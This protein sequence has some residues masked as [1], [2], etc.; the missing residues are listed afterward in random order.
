MQILNYSSLS[1][2][3]IKNLLPLINYAI[4]KEKMLPNLLLY[5][6]NKSYKHIKTRHK[7]KIQ[8][9]SAE[10]IHNNKKYLSISIFI[11]NLYGSYPYVSMYR[12]KAGEATI[13]NIAEQIVII[14]AHE[15]RH[16]YQYY[17]KLKLSKNW[18]KSEDDA[19]IYAIKVLESFK[20]LEKPLSMPKIK[21]NTGKIIVI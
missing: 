8:G 7:D 9:I 21:Q 15:F 20:K 14:L 2:N 17:K 1:N 5:I 4:P 3:T 16:C 10:F 11:D 18:D 19:E 13:N 6:E 12:E